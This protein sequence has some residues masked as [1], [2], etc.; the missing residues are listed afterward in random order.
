MR[1]VC[2]A[3]WFRFAYHE[4][5]FW[6]SEC[7]YYLL[8]TYD[9]VNLWW[10]YPA[11]GNEASL[12]YKN[13]LETVPFLPFKKRRIESEKYSTCPPP[14]LSF[15]CWSGAE[16]EKWSRKFLMKKKMKTIL[17]C[18]NTPWLDTWCLFSLCT[19]RHSFSFPSHAR[20]WSWMEGAAW[21]QTHSHCYSFYLKITHTMSMFL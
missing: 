17:S 16:E 2:C 7:I 21:T 19:S 20:T 15:P 18:I 11:L 3:A 6:W 12:N 8:G 13:L 1:F 4:M 9:N 5:S 14:R 10:R